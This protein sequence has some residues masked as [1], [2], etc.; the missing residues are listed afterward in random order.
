[1]KR[2]E[3][4]RP[5]R[6][7]A[8][9]AVRARVDALAHEPERHSRCDPPE[10]CRAAGA[11][12]A[13][14]DERADYEHHEP[15]GARHQWG[16]ATIEPSHGPK[17]GDRGKNHTVPELRTALD[18]DTDCLG[19]G[20]KF[21]R[22]RNVRNVRNGHNRTG[23]TASETSGVSID[24][25]HSDTPGHR[26]PD[27]H[28]KPDFGQWGVSKDARPDQTGR[29]APGHKRPLATRAREAAAVAI[30]LLL[31][32]PVFAAATDFAQASESAR[33]SSAPTNR[34]PAL[35]TRQ[36]FQP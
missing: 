12:E 29:G 22:V 6:V 19:H 16:L 2:S 30:A 20:S 14:D 35:S 8:G 18:V 10:I 28:E 23:V 13:H 32:T 1:V 15:H 17:Q 11:L 7:E 4:L 9:S 25:G 21:Y 34:G 27:F 31:T 3:R 5:R 26:T 36:R 33:K 24:T